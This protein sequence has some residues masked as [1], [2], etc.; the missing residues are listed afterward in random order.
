MREPAE[1]AFGSVTGDRR[2]YAR[3]YDIRLYV[4]RPTLAVEFDAKPLVFDMIY[5]TALNPVS[6]RSSTLPLQGSFGERVLDS[7]D[8]GVKRAA[9]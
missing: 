6:P 1:L 3:R 8:R 7:R 4:L 2:S 9:E 5:E